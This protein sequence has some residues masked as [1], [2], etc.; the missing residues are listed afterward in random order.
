M[1]WL[2]ATPKPPEG[3]RRDK[4]GQVKTLS[5]REEMKAND[6]SPR[7]PPL[8]SEYIISRLLEIGLTE[9]AGMGLAPLSW[10]SIQAW[11]SV[12]GIRLSRWEARMV[13]TLSI[14]YLAFG[15]KSESENCPPPWHS[16]VVTEREKEVELSQ[17]Q[18]VLG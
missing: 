15:K 10:Q 12:M 13:R 6:L 14:E 4:K 5:R 17:L 1:A 11:Q 2:N 7:M 16:G 8:S 3:S 9:A 18:S